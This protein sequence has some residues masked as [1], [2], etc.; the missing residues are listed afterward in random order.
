[1]VTRLTLVGHGIPVMALARALGLCL[2]LAVSASSWAQPWPAK[3]VKLIVPF[4]AGTNPD[5][6]GRVMMQT[7][8]DAFGRQFFVE[9][10]V[11]GGGIVAAEAAAK[12][13]PDGY[14]LYFGTTGTMSGAPALRPKLNYDP[15]KS[16]A[17]ITLF[18]AAPAVLIVDSAMPVNNLKEFI[19]YAKARPG[20]LTFG[21]SGAAGFLHIAGEGLNHAAGIKLFH[22]PYKGANQ[23]LVDM[24]AGR[25]DVMFDTIVIYTP[26]L[27][28]GK[29]KALAV[30]YPQ[31]LAGRPD[32][33]TMSES[34]LPG[35]EFVAYFGLVAP[36][37]T[38]PEI[39]TRLNTEVVKAL[40]LPD[41]LEQ[42]RK[43]GLEPSPMTP[44]QYA[45]LIADDGEKWKRLVNQIGV[46]LE[47]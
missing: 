15:V 35:F 27:A 9:N 26:H 18:A 6:L 1:M 8:S 39:I 46:K 21:S 43:M 10:L 12:A 3:P 24:L 20:K 2:L 28:S 33:P 16:F 23:A 31:R 42:L 32:I 38:P 30:A 4:P 22:V 45:K 34:G 7:L 29:L 17:P 41:V 36:A 14:T 5:P 25:L 47:D 13:A 37:G 40:S 44:A 11:G 19:E